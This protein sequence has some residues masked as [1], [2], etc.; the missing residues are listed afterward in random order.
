MTFDGSDFGDPVACGVAALCLQNVALPP[1]PTFA[2]LR[3]PLRPGRGKEAA[4]AVRPF[5][6][7]GR[8]WFLHVSERGAA[9]RL[10]REKMQRFS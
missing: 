9:S 10:G 6:L 8:G 2:S 7:D 5:F 3:P 1:S 4:L